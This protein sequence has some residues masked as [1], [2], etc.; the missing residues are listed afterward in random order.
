MFLHRVDKIYERQCGIKLC[1]R[2]VEKVSRLDKLGGVV[3]HVP[4]HFSTT[5]QGATSRGTAA[6]LAQH[7]LPKWSRTRPLFQTV[8]KGPVEDLLPCVLTPFD[9]LDDPFD[10]DLG[11]LHFVR[12]GTSDDAPTAANKKISMS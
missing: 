6:M 11:F 3:S 9:L 10:G 5:A 7:L 12:I 1:V 8:F 4:P 2:Q